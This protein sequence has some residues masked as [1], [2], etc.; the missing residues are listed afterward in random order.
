[1]GSALFA[2]NWCIF[3]AIAVALLGILNICLGLLHNLYPPISTHHVF[4]VVASLW[5]L[6]PIVL[7]AVRWNVMYQWALRKSKEKQPDL[8]SEYQ[9]R[10]MVIVFGGCVFFSLYLTYKDYAEVVWHVTKFNF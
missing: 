10:L 9:T 4:Y 8:D 2:K 3:C 5:M 7:F 1:M 6:P